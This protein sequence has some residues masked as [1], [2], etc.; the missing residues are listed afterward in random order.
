LPCLLALRGQISEVD[1]H[2]QQRLGEE[3]MLS[4]LQNKLGTAGLV[5]AVV[6][7]VAALTGA[8][9]AAGGLTKQQEKQVKK[10]AKKFA[11]KDGAQGPA[12]PQGPVGAKG[13]TGSPGAPGAPG[14]DGEDGDPG[15]PGE[16]GVCSEANP[17]C[18]LPSG[19]TLVG[20]FSVGQNN[21][22]QVNLLTPISFVLEYPGTP[23]TVVYVKEEGEEEE[24]CPGSYEDPQ[25]KAGFLCLY[26][27]SESINKP[28]LAFSSVTTAGAT[29]VFQPAV[30][31]GAAK[32]VIMPG[33]WAVNAA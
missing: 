24:N 10:I 22:E 16:A 11:G 28:S 17:E 2:H 33:T 4:R 26:A 1:A 6:A 29:V 27:S 18:V 8:A 32:P 9:F 3:K 30:V 5:V 21:K 14:K 25:A 13:D 12:G 15:E 23:P 7:L 20:A 31:E 19:S